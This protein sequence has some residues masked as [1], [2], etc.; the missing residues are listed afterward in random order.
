MACTDQHEARCKLGVIVFGR[1]RP[2][3]DPEW[4]AAMT[5]RVRDALAATEFD[6]V[7]PPDTVVDDT[8]LCRALTAFEGAGVDALVALQTTMADARMAPTLHQRWCDPV[9]LWA[10]PENPKGDMIS[11]CSLVGAHNWGSIL[12]HLNHPF[13]IVCGDPQ[14][15]AVIADLAHAAR[16]AQTVRKLRLAKVGV[17]AGTAPGFFA[18]AADAP[19][20][21]RRLGP[22][23]Q[24]VSLQQYADVVQAVS[25]DDIASDVARV[26]ALG[27]PHKDTSDDDLPTA[28]RL[29]LAFRQL[30]HDEAI[31]ALAVRCWPEM[32]NVFGQWPYLG[33][34]RLA[35]QG[36][37][38]SME[39]DADGAVG[40]LIAESLG[41]GRCYISDWLEHDE[42]T[43][44][45]WHAGNLPFALSHP[46]G[47]ERGPTIAKHFNFPRPAVVE[48]TLKPD[49][50]VTIFRLWHC[51]GRYLMTACDA[52]T[53]EPRRHLMG[54]NG[55]VRLTDR[56]PHDW[57]IE[58]C[59][60]GMPHHVSVCR[61][62]HVSLLKQFARVMGIEW[63]D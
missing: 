55:L 5:R 3:F 52:E 46:I 25:E 24:T 30:M 14:D 18:M 49:R 15:Q 53:I 20:M 34:T 41:M 17:V 16:I 7:E 9:I 22:Q 42:K 23:V 37:A 58:L 44:T 59:H 31:D 51:D 54:T 29:Y 56:A 40:A 63:I 2:G 19:A 39:G 4:G 61:G 1:K 12:R 45:L 28:S 6:I 11:S 26:T 48:S 21:T 35:E 32:P 62:H 33:M 43:I 10:T 36:V 8:S 60:A 13:E 38:I 57:L 50:P 47:H 27:L